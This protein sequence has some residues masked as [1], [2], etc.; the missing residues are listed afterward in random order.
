MPAA[1]DARIGL[2][3]EGADRL[4]TTTMHPIGRIRGRFSYIMSATASAPAGRNAPARG[5]RSVTPGIV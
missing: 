5:E 1:Y 2:C 4:L 3:A